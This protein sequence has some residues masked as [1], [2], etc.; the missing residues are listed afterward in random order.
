MQQTMTEKE[1]IEKVTKLNVPIKAIISEPNFLNTESKYGCFYNGAQY[2]V[3]E[4]TRHG[5]DT[6]LCT[7]SEM[8]ALSVLYDFLA[9]G[10]K[11]VTSFSEKSVIKASYVVK[12]PMKR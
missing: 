5:A 4:K 2:I 8:E 9:N 1:F 6:L 10:G 3:Y 12:S 7:T 11:D